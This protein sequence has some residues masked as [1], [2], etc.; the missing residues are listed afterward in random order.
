MEIA[1]SPVIIHA[2]QFLKKQ[3]FPRKIRRKK[4]SLSLAKNTAIN[5]R[6]SGRRGR[7]PS[8]ARVY[9][10]ARVRAT[11]IR[12]PRPLYTRVYIYTCYTHIY[13]HS[14]RRMCV[15]I[16]VSVS[17]PPRNSRALGPENRFSRAISHTQ[18]V[19]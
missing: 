5:E 13:T 4:L 19:W 9:L 8:L 15:Y 1:K 16:S 14:K 18:D 12:R 10:F 7:H 17:G 11:S 3:L 2:L 6:P